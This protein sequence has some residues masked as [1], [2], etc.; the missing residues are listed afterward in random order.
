RLADV[1][2][3]VTSQNRLRPE[4]PL[5]RAAVRTGHVGRHRAEVGRAPGEGYAGK[6]AGRVGGY[7]GEARGGLGGPG[8]AQVQGAR[9]GGVVEE[10][11]A[12]R[13]EPLIPFA[14]RRGADH[15]EGESITPAQDPLG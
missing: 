6:S 12:A 4:T 10:T 5:G 9:A 11:A 2:D 13:Q 8:R 14:Q 3:H 1:A 7:G 15:L